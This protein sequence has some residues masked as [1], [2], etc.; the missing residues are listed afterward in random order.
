MSVGVRSTVTLLYCIGLSAGHAGGQSSHVQSCVRGVMRGANGVRERE[1]ELRAQ[2][3]ILNHYE[4]AEAEEGRKRERGNACLMMYVT[5]WLYLLRITSSRGAFD[6]VKRNL[7]S[8]S[9]KRERESRKKLDKERGREKGTKGRGKSSV[10]NGLGFLPTPNN[11]K[12]GYV[13]VFL[14]VSCPYISKSQ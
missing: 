2:L 8:W 7:Q 6:G 9:G 10:S 1:R 13:P 3:P 5:S 12:R 11:S 14:L 4:E